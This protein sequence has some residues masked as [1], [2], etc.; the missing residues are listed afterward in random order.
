[1]W[2]KSSQQYLVRVMKRTFRDDIA[3]LLWFLL[4]NA[5]V[6]LLSY[7]SLS[8]LG[9]N[10][11]LAES[12]VGPVEIC[13]G[14]VLLSGGGAAG[15]LLAAKPII[16]YFLA[17]RVV[18]D[19]MGAKVQQLQ[20]IVASQAGRIGIIAPQLAVY[21]AP[22]MNAFAVGGGRRR[23][24]LVVS[25][26][27][28]DSLTLDEL[29][30]VIGHEMTHITSGDVLTLSLMQGVVNMCVHF[31]AR[32]LGMGLDRLLFRDSHF[33]PVYKSI[34]LFLQLTLGGIASLIVMWFSRRREFRADAGGAQL[35]GHAEM[36][37]ALRS[38]RAGGQG[39]PARPVF[40]VFG[41]NSHFLSNGFWR[42]FSSHPTLTER[43]KALCKPG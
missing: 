43:I 34:S 42:L 7:L 33:G 5:G 23:A 39:D 2:K 25:Q 32:L 19:S 9:L 12:G 35:A 37:A 38:L 10:A 6:C 22:E 15:M 1:M 4:T 36:M 21:P 24:M 18:D 17:V 16:R 30:A 3:P 41:Q 8:L 31:P 20:L 11:V 13:L 27:L 40:T 28:L 26:G 14:I 29:S